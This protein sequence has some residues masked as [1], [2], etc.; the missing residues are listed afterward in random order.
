MEKIFLETLFRT[1][2]ICSRFIIK[3][4]NRQ[5]NFFL[6]FSTL[7]YFILCILHTLG[8]AIKPT[9]YIIYIYLCLF[10]Q[11]FCFMWTAVYTRE[12][13][14]INEHTNIWINLFQANDVYICVYIY[15]YKYIAMEE[16]IA[17]FSHVYW[18]C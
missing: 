15:M 13:K 10:F 14:E 11:Y 1:I 12:H 18:R 17:N 4:I 6:I 16:N 8:P 9:Y 3:V 2:N 7:F 5:A